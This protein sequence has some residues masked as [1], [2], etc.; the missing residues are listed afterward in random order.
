MTTEL[1][2]RS[3]ATEAEVRAA[4]GVLCER[5]QVTQARINGQ[6][7]NFED[8]PDPAPV[9][10]EWALARS[11]EEYLERYPDGPHAEQA[12]ALVDG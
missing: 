10:S 9:V 11:P 5:I 4:L 1:T 12:R 3:A 8:L 2:I 7:I 6:P